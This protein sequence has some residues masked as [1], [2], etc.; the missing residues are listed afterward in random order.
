MAMDKQEDKEREEIVVYT[1]AWCADWARVKFLLDEYDVAYREIDVDQ[2][3][4]AAA[5]VRQV[6]NG[7][8]TVPTLVF[9]D[10]SIM[11]EPALAA[12]AKKLGLTLDRDLW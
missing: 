9:P 11:A 1:T 4:A 3:T 6:N 8:R 7:R 5:F 10:G 12:L 2:D